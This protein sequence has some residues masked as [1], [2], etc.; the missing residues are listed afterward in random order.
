VTPR[1]VLLVVTDG[2]WD[3][4][5]RTL[6]SA[7]QNLTYDFSEVVIVNDHEEGWEQ[8]PDLMWELLGERW[9]M[10]GGVAGGRR[11][12]A[13]A[14]QVG[15]DHLDD[16]DYV[17]HLEDDWTFP[18]PVDVGAMVAHLAA[19]PEL[20]QVALLRQPVSPDEQATGS[21]YGP[22]PDAYTETGG[23]VVQRRLFTFNPCVYPRWVTG[24]GAGLEQEVTDK[25]LA[26]GKHFAYLGGLDDPPRCTHIGVRRSAG[27]RW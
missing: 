6:E 2:R 20:A 13:G 8:F 22:N 3:Y 25:L 10:V 17:F 1:V 27:Y 18:D 23:L 26:D 14:I 4:L 24:Y 15:W 16:C 21:L 7:V 9:E 5:E 11:G 12:M 19:D